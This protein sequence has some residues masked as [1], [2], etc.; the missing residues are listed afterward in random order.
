MKSG[1]KKMG[2]SRRKKKS[3]S[4]IRYFCLLVL[5]VILLSSV[6]VGDDTRAYGEG[7]NAIFKNP[8]NP[9]YESND[10]GVKTS[11][12]IRVLNTLSGETEYG[13]NAMSLISVSETDNKKSTMKKFSDILDMDIYSNLC[14]SATVENSADVERDISLS[15]LLPTRKEG[16]VS[17]LRL[18][19]SDLDIFSGNLNGIDIKYE[20]EGRVITEAERKS[21]K[22]LDFNKVKAIKIDGKIAA[23][24]KFEGLLPMEILEN[25]MIVEKKDDFVDDLKTI[26]EVNTNNI[27]DFK[28]EYRYPIK[29]ELN[30]SV[31]T[32]HGS[33]R[34]EDFTN[35]K[36]VGIARRDEESYEILPSDVIEKFP[37]AN[38]AF[39]SM[40]TTD[41]KK[42][43]YVNAYSFININTKDLQN[44][45]KDSGY[46]ALEKNGEFQEKYHFT[47]GEKKHIYDGGLELNLGKKDKH[48]HMLSKVYVEFQKVIHTKDLEIVQ[49][50]EWNKFDNLVFAKLQNGDE[51]IEL[52]RNRIKV[53]GNVDAKT[54]GE[55]SVKYSY[56][57]LPNTW[58]S[59]TCKVKVVEKKES[60]ENRSES[61]GDSKVKIER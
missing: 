14:L 43:N 12:K 13:S 27:F 5:S 22:Q 53:E 29:K 21:G 19:N 45:V 23:G 28:L 48:G 10:N 8:I 31:A 52:D 50:S 38:N 26:E 34:I 33:E 37:N 32:C 17:E 6:L 4:F 36:I 40:F 2:R 15:I 59:D 56:E 24:Q 55:Y 49:G 44:L 60:T 61:G 39:S 41:E 11:F 35:G 47:V 25:K 51:I 46:Y 42:D 30:L 18:I 7:R 57:I 9:D 58:I 3:K 54:K 16:I 1:I 20:L